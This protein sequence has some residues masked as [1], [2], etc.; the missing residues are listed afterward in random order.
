[1]ERSFSRHPPRGTHAPQSIIYGTPR[2]KFLKADSTCMV[3]LEDNKAAMPE[4]INLRVILFSE[5]RRDP[6]SGSLKN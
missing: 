6:K 5:V 1:M 2:G 4:C 3:G